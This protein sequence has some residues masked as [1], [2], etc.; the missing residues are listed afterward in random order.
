[1][2]YPAPTFFFVSYFCNA[3]PGL[4]SAPENKRTVVEAFA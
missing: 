3:L 4:E 1:M 2:S